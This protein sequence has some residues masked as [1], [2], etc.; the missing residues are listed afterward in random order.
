L[1]DTYNEDRSPSKDIGNIVRIAI[2]AALGIII[3]AIVSNQSVNLLMN[4]AEFGDVF[5]KPLYYSTI[6]GLILASIALVR[7]NFVSRHSM[8]WYGIRTIINLVKRSEYDQPRMV[9]YS[10]FR[11]S[12]Q[13]F[14][15][16]QVMKIVLFAPLFSNLLFGM[17]VDYITKGNDIGLGSIG[18]IFGIPFAEVT[19]DMAFA[20][21]NV[22]SMFPAL[23]LLIPAL[24]AAVSLRLLLYIGVAGTVNIVTQYILDAREGKPR[25]LSYI[26]TIELIIGATVFWLGFNLFFTSSIDYN[27]RYAIAGTVA[28]GAAFLAYSFFD[29][30]RARVMI[31][32]TKRHLYSRLI[33]I[34]VVVALVGSIMAINHSIA[35][36]KK[37]EW[38]GPYTAQEIAVNRYMHD[39]EVLKLLTMTL[40]PQ[41]SLPLELNQ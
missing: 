22:F 27:T 1:W 33:T 17:T 36:A 25:F 28:L 41:P 11:M 29:R 18:A 19:M 40:D 15:L 8:T 34:G 13:S 32:P 39:L 5:T 12:P 38:R 14:G 26:S 10:E 7:A 20:Q 2:F 24:L 9:R 30:I 23:T 16:W 6:S 31:Y 4:V 3:F 37:I 35:D 21:A